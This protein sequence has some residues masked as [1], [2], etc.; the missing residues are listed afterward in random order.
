[1]FI[2]LEKSATL[3]NIQLFFVTLPVI[4]CLGSA[5]HGKASE[6]SETCVSSV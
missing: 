6:T 2:W 3:I 4:V 5:S 1:M